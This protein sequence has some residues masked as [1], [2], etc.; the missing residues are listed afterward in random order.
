MSDLVL[1]M[2]DEILDQLNEPQPYDCN[3]DA[4]LGGI[5]SAMESL[6][7]LNKLKAVI[8]KQ[9]NRKPS[10]SSIKIGML[11]MERIKDSVGIFK[12]QL[13]VAQECFTED[14]VSL[15][16]ITAVMQ[17]IWDAIVRTFKA[18]WDAITSLFSSNSQKKA[19]DESKQAYESLKK[20]EKTAELAGQEQTLSKDVSNLFRYI[21]EDPR[22][23]DLRQ[24]AEKLIETVKI[25]EGT[26]LNL[27]VCN[28]NVADFIHKL[29]HKKISANDFS[30]V[31]QAMNFFQTYL[32][33]H[34]SK[35]DEAILLDYIKRTHPEHFEKLDQKTV[36][37]LHGLTRGNRVIA[38]MLDTTGDDTN[39]YV[40][41]ADIQPREGD[42]KIRVPNANEAL[43]HCQT[44]MNL[45]AET[46]D[47]MDMFRAKSKRIMS[48][49]K[50]L[51]AGLSDL[52]KM[53]SGDSDNE[54]NVLVVKFAQSVTKSMSSFLKDM[55]RIVRV[56]ELSSLDHTKVV[57]A[58]SKAYKV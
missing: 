9:K 55:V 1:A 39:I 21:S 52:F 17:S 40:E 36:R 19:H 32:T 24:E 20:T 34:F 11:A 6:E 48:E 57:T 14:S 23:E 51:L 25:V 50:N 54:D 41:I 10:K 53:Y 7:T 13:V 18:I 35:G 3:I 42:A 5:E 37:T 45:T 43:R 58:I 49:Q 8:Q 26:I 12:D 33:D 15:E 47:M 56:V 46:L 29:R 38:Y 30:G 28:V 22:V 27:E 2:E 4:M 16:G 44:T 31:H